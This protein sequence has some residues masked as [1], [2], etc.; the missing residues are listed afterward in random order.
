MIE[1]LAVLQDVVLRG[2]ENVEVG[3]DEVFVFAGLRPRLDPQMLRVD[4]LRNVFLLLLL[5]L[6]LELLL[7]PLLELLLDGLSLGPRRS[8]EGVCP[9]EILILES[10]VSVSI[11]TGFSL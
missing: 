9:E 3:F 4:F 1:L 2:V 6:L 11:T 10:K 7:A 5:E 8:R